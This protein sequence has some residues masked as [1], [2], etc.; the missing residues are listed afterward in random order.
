MWND[1]LDHEMVMDRGG[2]LGS[3]RKIKTNFQYEE[4]LD[5]AKN[6][7][8]RKALSKFRTSSH[9]LR[10]ETGRYTSPKTDREDRVCVKCH[11]LGYSHVDDKMH[12]L[13]DCKFLGYDQK[14][15]LDVANLKCKNFSNLSQEEN[16][17]K[18]VNS[19]GEM[20]R[21][22][23]KFC[24]ECFRKKN[25]MNDDRPALCLV[26]IR[27][28]FIFWSL[29]MRNCV[30]SAYITMNLRQQYMGHVAISCSNRLCMLWI[31]CLVYDV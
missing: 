7:Q 19:G 21:V 15:L 28:G 5:T 6:G 23:A 13:L 24:F 1:R 12:F 30:S 27:L 2:K 25:D 26:V 8:H 9:R 3:H 10:I 29:M 20:C 16:Y 22:V 31:Y 18:M 11:A 14:L 17:F 4:Y